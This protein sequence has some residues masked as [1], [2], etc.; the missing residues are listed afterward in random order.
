MTKEFSSIIELKAIREEKSRLSERES[1]LAQP[2]LTNLDMIPIVF[3]WFKDLAMGLPKRNKSI[4]TKEF[5]FIILFLYSPGTLAGG[6]MKGGVRKV[7]GEVLGI[8][9]KSS[10]SDK[11]GIITFYYR[12]YKY[13]RQDLNIIYPA[14]VEKLRQQGYCR[15]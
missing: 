8:V 5:I 9:G 4:L 14:I 7:L 6:K 12:T 11:I 2:M 15:E 3:G 10:I 13:F 1:E